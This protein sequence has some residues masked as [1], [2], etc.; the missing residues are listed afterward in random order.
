[1]ATEYIYLVP[2]NASGR[3]LAIKLA[4][5]KP[6]TIIPVTADEMHSANQLIALPTRNNA[7]GD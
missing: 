7:D 5:A 3:S 6:G 2:D 4:K 1:M